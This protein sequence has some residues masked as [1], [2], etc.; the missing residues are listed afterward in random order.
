[1]A[2]GKSFRHLPSP[3]PGRTHALPFPSLRPFSSSQ[4]TRPIER[5]VSLVF[6]RLLAKEPDILVNANDCFPSKAFGMVFFHTIAIAI[7]IT[8]TRKGHTHTIIV[9]SRMQS[10]V[11]YSPGDWLRQLRMA[12]TTCLVG[13]YVVLALPPLFD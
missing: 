6:V 2:Q 9:P 13:Y 4:R 7:E 5:L 10:R 12:F 8:D 11:H 1:M 3:H